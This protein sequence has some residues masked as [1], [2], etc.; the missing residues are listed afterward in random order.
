MKSPYNPYYIHAEDYELYYQ[1]SKKWKFHNLQ[2][3]LLKYRI[4]NSSVSK[5]HGGVQNANSI[6]IKKLFFSRIHTPI[7]EEELQ[8]FEAL[9]YQNYQEIT[10]SFDK[11]KVLLESMILGNRKEKFIEIN[12]MEMVIKSLWLNYCYHTS[13]LK[14][15][16]NSKI[17][18]DQKLLKNVIK[19]KWRVKSLFIK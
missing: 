7:S 3:S 2:E 14:K 5:Q 10:L 12:Y 1:L 19:L 9:N 4:H 16:L 17:L 11:M 18:S 13:T 15:Y 6:K 8:A